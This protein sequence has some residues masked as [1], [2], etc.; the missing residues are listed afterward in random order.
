M[1]IFRYRIIDVLALLTLA[2]LV[3]GAHNVGFRVSIPR[4]LIGDFNSYRSYEIIG[5]ET[6]PWHNPPW[7]FSLPDKTGEE[8]AILRANLIPSP[9]KV[10]KRTHWFR[11]FY[12]VILTIL[13]ASAVLL[14]WAVGRQIWRS[15]RTS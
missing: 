15:S 3:L 5:P 1:K 9:Q 6:T 13:T 8:Y 7:H 12:D 10:V 4:F 2:S 14:V 11:L